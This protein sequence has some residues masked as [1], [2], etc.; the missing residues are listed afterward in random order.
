MSMSATRLWALWVAVWSFWLGAGLVEGQPV[1]RAV[2]WGYNASGQ[3][4]VPPSLVQVIAVAAG[5]YHSLALKSDGTVV[6]WGGN[7]SGQAN[8]PAGLTNAMAIAAGGYH[9]LA[10][11]SD[12]TVVGWGDN[13]TGEISIPAGLTNVMAIAAGYSHSLALRGD[14]TILAWGNNNYGQATVPANLSNVLAIAGGGYHTLVLNSNNTVAAWGYND[15]GQAMVPA[16]LTNVIGIAGGGLHSLALRSDGSVVAW[17]DN[18]YGQITVPASVTNALAVAAGLYHSLA[19]KADGT[20]VAWGNNNYGQTTI[21]A[22]LTQVVAV[23]GGGSHSLALTT[24]LLT[25]LSGPP[26]AV[27]LAAGDSTNLSIS[28]LP[29]PPFTC[30]WFFNSSAITGATGTNLNITNFSLAKAGAYTI[31]ASNQYSF[32][33]AVSVLRLANSPVI[34]VD[35]VDVGGGATTRIDISQITMSSSLG[36]GATIYYTLDGTEPDFTALPYTGPFSLTNS[37]TIRAIVYAFNYTNSAETA[38]IYVQIWPTYPLAAGTSGG[39][40]VTNF[41]VPYSGANRYLSNTVVTLTATAAT[42]WSFLGWTG[43]VTA[44]TNITTVLLTKPI[45]AQAVFG[46]QLVL[47]TTGLGQ[48]IANPPGGLYAYG[49]NVQ[50]TA[51]PGPGRYFF[52]WAGSASG[53]ANSLLFTV[54]NPAAVTGLFAPIK[55]NE[56]YLIV[57][58]T[59]I[60]AVSVSPAQNVYSNGATVTLTAT[61][62]T[63]SVFAGW[64]GDTNGIMNPL[65]LTLGTNL[66]VVA[67]FVPGTPSNPPV[68]LQQPLS[69]TLSAG[70][71]TTLSVQATGNSP[72]TYQWLLNGTPLTNATAPS[73]SLTNLTDAQV[74]LYD[75]IVTGPGG[76]ATSDPASVALFGM[77]LMSSN[78]QFFPLLILNAATG[79]TYDLEFSADLSQTNWTLLQTAT[80]QSDH[81]YYLDDSVVD[82]ARRFYRA[83]P[84]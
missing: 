73:L 6:A 45:V 34:L 4:T 38:P 75:V 12:G 5:G 47:I 77:E 29:G 51:K 36:P 15:S 7:T 68:I 70:S 69:R 43:D 44:S 49:T 56:V 61:P 40:T 59:G 78:A 23:E 63:N 24:N 41:P 27:E 37:A 31:T 53:F 18:S 30:Q 39:G 62:A 64:G 8:V 35:G 71:D 72:F 55:S 10:L 21:P 52:G 32:F 54:T 28:V 80:M 67:N 1:G 48:I 9:S 13:S 19:V 76:S 65:T 33:S 16:G 74:G 17:G 14:G 46:T 25:V 66:L 79:T 84:E 81:F 26:P 57:Q 22:G 11:K 50:L 20:V 58:Q 82:H 42:N 83:A 2:A 3:A 60:G